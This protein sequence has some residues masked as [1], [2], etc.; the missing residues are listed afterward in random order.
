MIKR[1]KTRDARIARWHAPSLVPD[2][3]EAPRLSHKSSA[4]EP[5]PP[6]AEPTKSEADEAAAAAA[7]AAAALE[8][9]RAEKAAAGYAEGLARGVEEGRA[10]GHGAGLDAGRRAA[11]ADA[12][13]AAARFA[14]LFD[15]LGGEIKVLDDAVEDAVVALALELARRVVGAEVARSREA[16]AGLIR[17]V[18]AE[19]PIDTGTPRVLLHPDDLAALRTHLPDIGSGTVALVA[20]E[21]IEPG[22]CRVLA[23]GV[24]NATRPDRRWIERSSLFEGDLTLAARWRA[25]MLALFD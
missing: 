7:A 21:T 13:T 12:A 3:A 18:L 8:A 1:L 9:L 11:E 24:D 6:A 23:D 14:K 5:R 17:Q 22:G 16:L 4:A 20:D 25:A 2:E 10:Q 15:A 19:I